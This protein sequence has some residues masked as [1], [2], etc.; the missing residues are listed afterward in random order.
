MRVAYL[1]AGAGGMYCG[2]CLRDNRLASVLIAQGRDV[3]L[4]PMYTP[5]KVDE[6]RVGERRVRYGG[7]NVFLQQ[8][9]SLFTLM[10]AVMAR[11]LDAEV[12]LRAAGRAAGSTRAE[13]LG[14][15]TVSVLAGEEGR[16]KRELDKLLADLRTLKPDVVNLPNLM[17]LGQARRIRREL[18]IPIVCTLS[19]ED[20]FLDALPEPHR[21]QAFELIAERSADVDAFIAVTAYFAKRSVTHFALPAERMHVVPMG[22]HAHEFAPSATPPAE[23]FTIGYFARIC[24]EKGLDRLARAFVALR[25]AGCDCRLKIGGYLARADR[26]YLAHVLREIHAAG[27][28]HDVAHVG[29]TDRAGKIAFLQS[30][31]VL[32]VPTVYPEAKGF[33]ILEALAAG[34]PVVQP[35]HG[36]FPELLEATGGGLLYDHADESALT[37]ALAQ[38]ADDRDLHAHHARTGRENVA[39]DFTAEIMAEQTWTLYSQLTGRT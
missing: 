11:M 15:M 3:H 18:N 8:A 32:S 9:S 27:F 1:A 30:L 28:G 36:S 29:E 17:F 35:R 21:T 5:L 4:W 10:P 16:Q 6:P 7:I 23:P 37:R 26:D 14:P 39:R 31:H 25:R 13:K 19:G 24:P 22:I 20:L 2:S 34:T 38:L 12:L 33:Y